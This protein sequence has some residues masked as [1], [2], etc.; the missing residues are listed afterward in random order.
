MIV[1]RREGGNIRQTAMV[2]L[3]SGATGMTLSHDGKLLVVAATQ[4]I[5]F[6][7]VAALSSGKGRALLGSIVDPGAGAIYANITGDDK[8]LFVSEER[9]ASIAVIDLPK[10]RG[11]GF[12]SS[13]I[14][15]RIPVGI[16]P[17]ALTFSADGKHLF[18]TSELA[19]PAWGWPAA[20]KPEGRG[21][22]ASLRDPEGAIVVI[23]VSRAATDPASAVTARVPAGCSPVRMA[24]SP[25][26]DRVYVTAR[27]S[28]AV[29][30]FDTAKLLADPAH[31]KL[32]SAAVG[33][34]PVPVVVLDG[35]RRVVAGNSD[36]FGG[37][38]TRQS[39]TV[40]DVAQDGAMTAAGS[41]PA[42]SFPREMALSHDGRTLFLTNF[43]S[44]SLQVI[45]LTH[46]PLDRQ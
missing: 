22:D 41:I 8:T 11:N 29:L 4:S 18:T 31:S 7:D 36:R 44:K 45:D 2:P 38:E 25:A 1:L 46:L 39:L 34:S 24:Q 23:D 19:A 14:L 42:G 12:K 9:L 16:A 10:A 35:G 33:S 5:D 3:K 6:L 15:G 21:G 26:G 43:A 20:C 13:A 32:A 40:L 17:I 28:N 30:A 27:N 37:G